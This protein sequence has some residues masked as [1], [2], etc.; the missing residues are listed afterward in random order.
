MANFEQIVR[1]LVSSFT[2]H[3]SHSIQCCHQA[4]RISKKTSLTNTSETSLTTFASQVYSPSR[5]SR[6]YLETCCFHSR[7][8]SPSSCTAR[9]VRDRH[10][11][12]MSKRDRYQRRQFGGHRWRRHTAPVGPHIPIN[13]IIPAKRLHLV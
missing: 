5:V 2:A 8:G 10:G 7:I 12:R 9:R 1:D 11:R 3:T 6:S 4:I 13:R